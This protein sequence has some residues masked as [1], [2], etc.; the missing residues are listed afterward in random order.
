MTASE[1]QWAGRRW[2]GLGL[3]VMFVL[4]GVAV[5]VGAL[6][7]PYAGVGPMMMSMPFFGFGWGILGLLFFLFFFGWIFR[8]LMWG[9]P[10]GYHHGWG[11]DRYDAA[12]ILRMRYAR[13][14]ITKDQFDSMMRDI[15]K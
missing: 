14:E 8:F 11:W 9:R 2:I 10:F 4:I 7:R 1:S 5:V 3:F 12:D 6:F 15:G 13:G